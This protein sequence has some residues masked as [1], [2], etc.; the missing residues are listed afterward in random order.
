[1][2]DIYLNNGKRA[3]WKISVPNEYASVKNYFIVVDYRLTIKWNDQ[4]NIK[5][6]VV[7]LLA[8]KKGLKFWNWT[9]YLLH[10]RSCHTRST[11]NIGSKFW[12][13]SV[14]TTHLPPPTL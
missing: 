11:H 8:T 9:S 1:M 14:K 12:N 2:A 3:A 4:R 13:S 5:Q 7:R 10:Y 6:F